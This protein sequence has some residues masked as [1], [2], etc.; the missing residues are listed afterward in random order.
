[1]IDKVRL[2]VSNPVVRTGSSLTVE[3]KSILN[4]NGTE[5][6]DKPLFNWDKG[7]QF[8]AHKAYFNHPDGVYIDLKFSPFLYMPLGIIH[9]NPGKLLNGH[10][11]SNLTFSDC[12][13]A[14]NKADEIIDSVLVRSENPKVSRLDMGINTDMEKNASIYLYALSLLPNSNQMTL[15][16]YP[17]QSVFLKNKSRQFIAYDKTLEAYRKPGKKLRFESRFLN[18]NILKQRKLRELTDVFNHKNYI[19]SVARFFRD[20]QKMIGTLKNSPY[21]RA[22]S[23][24]NYEEIVDLFKEQAGRYWFSEMRSYFGDRY[25]AENIGGS[26]LFL[27]ALKTRGFRADVVSKYR[28]FAQRIKIDKA[29]VPPIV[30][31]EIQ[32]K[33]NQWRTILSS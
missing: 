20:L 25:L 13:S 23:L 22:M 12:E 17:G 30:L 32:D 18:A 14:R 7:G 29:S 19:N 33:L 1:M 8:E 10:N 15:F 6:L 24:D 11:L 5:F 28:K 3:R 2:I 9:Y 4:E 16:N 26:E 31:E 27:D 21:Q